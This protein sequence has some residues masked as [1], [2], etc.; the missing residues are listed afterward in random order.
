M[1]LVWQKKDFYLL[2]RKEDLITVY[3]YDQ[4]LS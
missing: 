2:Q 4:G 3:H 1:N